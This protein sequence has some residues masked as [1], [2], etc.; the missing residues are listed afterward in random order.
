MTAF[1]THPPTAE[2]LLTVITL[3]PLLVAWTLGFFSSPPGNGGS[4][5]VGNPLCCGAETFDHAPPH[6]PVLHL[7]RTETAQ[8]LRDLALGLRNAPVEQAAPL[9]KHFM[10]SPDP[11]LALFAQSMLQQGRERLQTTYSRL[12]NHHHQDDPRIAASLLETGLRL[13]SPA[14]ATPGEHEGRIQML[15]EKAAAQLVSCEHTPRLRAACARV[16]LAAGAPE[17]ADSIVSAMPEDSAL[18]HALEPGIRFALNI[19]ECAAAH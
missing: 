6:E 11:E 7:S 1:P 9:L 5:R 19:K 8:E 15:A 2:I 14:L 18:R 10:Q 3:V 4:I 13:A 12:Q 16:F 17:K